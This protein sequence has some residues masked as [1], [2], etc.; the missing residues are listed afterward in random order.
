[1]IV[2]IITI[3]MITTA[4]PSGYH[5]VAMSDLCTAAAIQNLFGNKKRSHWNVACQQRSSCIT[6]AALGTV[7]RL[8]ESSPV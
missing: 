3:A 8:Y 5:V 4:I 7:R 1:M 6:Q 2:A